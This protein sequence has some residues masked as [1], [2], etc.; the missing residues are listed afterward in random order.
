MKRRTRI[1]LGTVTAAALMT[2]YAPSP[3]AATSLPV[4]AGATALSIPAFTGSATLRATLTLTGALGGLLDALISPIVNQALN[5]LVAALQTLTFNTLVA[6]ALGAS[7]SYSAGT[8]A[9][10][11]SPGPAAFPADL[12]PSPCG[13][14][15]GTP[16]YNATSGLAPSLGSL[17]SLGLNLVDGY[18]QQV[19]AS[20]DATNPILAR[21]QLANPSVRVLP[22]VSSLANP[23]VTAGAVDA[24]ANCPNDGSAPSASAS[25]SSV[26]LLNGLVTFNVLSGDVANLNVNGVAYATLASLPV[27]TIAGVTVQPYGATALKVTVPISATQIVNALGLAGAVV[28]ELLGDSP[29]AS[30]NLAVIVGPRTSETSTAA[31][32]GGLAIGVDLSGSIT[33]NLLGL[34]GA[35]V[36][37]PSGVGGSNYGNVIDLRLAYATCAAG[38]NTPVGTPPI[39]P[40]LV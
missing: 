18:T 13:A 9:L 20:A 11:S 33:F 39:P 37:V 17:A 36:A 21:A 3:A 26:R 23:L 4:T 31:T 22:A 5:P 34:V 2:A 6:G 29:G 19:L 32:A 24:K 12:L 7:S 40:A 38:S 28:S 15:Y 14:A 8:P 30:F 16:C 35:T 25:A 27:L 10:Q 1:A